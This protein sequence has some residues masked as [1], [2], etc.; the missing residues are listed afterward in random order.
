MCSIY[1][2]YIYMNMYIEVRGGLKGIAILVL[3]ET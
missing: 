1:K 3:I 2:C